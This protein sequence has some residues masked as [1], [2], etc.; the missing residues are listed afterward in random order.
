[1]SAFVPVMWQLNGLHGFHSQYIC[2]VVCNGLFA[3]TD[4]DSDP[5]P[6]PFLYPAVGV[7]I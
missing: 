6:N 3:L 1:M 5:D 4:S 7:E 2:T